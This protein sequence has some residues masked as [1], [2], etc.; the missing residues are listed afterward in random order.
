M[1]EYCDEVMRWRG[2]QMNGYSRRAGPSVASMR[3][4]GQLDDQS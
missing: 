3:R 4:P 2:S 1:T